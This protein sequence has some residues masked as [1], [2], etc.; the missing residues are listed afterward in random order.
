MNWV[1]ILLFGWG[2]D[3]IWYDQQG[4]GE[5]GTCGKTGLN[6][7]RNPHNSLIKKEKSTVVYY[8]C[9]LNWRNWIKKERPGTL[10]MMT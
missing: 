6:A 5:R 10:S 3:F 9:A 2:R 1:F 8:S 7:E 4:N